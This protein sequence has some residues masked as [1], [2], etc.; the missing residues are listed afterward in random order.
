MTEPE[1]QTARK[2][3]FPLIAYPYIEVANVLT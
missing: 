3:S 2:K 1:A